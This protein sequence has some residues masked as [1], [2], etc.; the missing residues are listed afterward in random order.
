MKKL[1]ALIVLLVLFVSYIIM[2]LKDSVAATD[3]IEYCGTVIAVQEFPSGGWANITNSR[4][5]LQ[6]GQ[7]IR[8]HYGISLELGKVYTIK[9]DSQRNLVSIKQGT[10]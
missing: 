7:V 5:H 10:E 8:I 4:I 3:I 1:I 2:P 9:V 6:D